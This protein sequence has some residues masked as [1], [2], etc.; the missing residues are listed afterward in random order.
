MKLL[1]L[2][3]YYKKLFHQIGGTYYTP[4][5]RLQMGLFLPLL[6]GALI[7]KRGI[8]SLYGF[9]GFNI[10][11][12]ILGKYSQ[13][14]ILFLLPFYYLLWAQLMDLRLIKFLA[15]FIMALTLLFS[16]VEIS[17]EGERF[18]FYTEQLN[19]LIPPGTVAL[20]NMYSEYALDVGHYYDWRN[21]HY[22][23]ENAL[24][25]EDYIETREIEYI[26]FSEEL[27]FIYNKR[28]Y[29]NVIYGNPAHWYPELIEFTQSE[30]TLVG[31]FES[32]GYAMRITAYRYDKPWSVKIFKVNQ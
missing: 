14:A 10:A 8:I 32:P 22:L 6:I 11:L 17:K 4:N 31:E 24:S 1:K 20:G 2:P 3:G 27:S 16:L 26:I 12:I 28:P 5:I 23:R 29:W 25:L 18:S 9:L 30:C 7:R 21:L 19:Q 15:P 13:P